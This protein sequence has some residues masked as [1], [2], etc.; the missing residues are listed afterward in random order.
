MT[1]LDYLTNLCGLFH[2][3]SILVEEQYYFTNSLGDKRDYTFPKNIRL[4]VNVIKQLKF[5]LKMI[6]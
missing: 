1:K 5:K 3:K 2:I 6:S 4:K